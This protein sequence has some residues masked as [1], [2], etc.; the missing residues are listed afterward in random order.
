[1]YLLELAGL[2]SAYDLEFVLF[3]NKKST[4][5]NF[6]LYA[7]LDNDEIGTWACPVENSSFFEKHN[8]N[9]LDIAQYKAIDYMAQK[10]ADN[11]DLYSKQINVMLHT[12]GE[13]EV[14]APFEEPQ[15]YGSAPVGTEDSGLHAGFR[16]SNELNSTGTVLDTSWRG[17]LDK[18]D[19]L[20]NQLDTADFGPKT[21]SQQIKE[22]QYALRAAKSRLR[23]TRTSD[24]EKTTNGV[25]ESGISNSLVPAWGNGKSDICK[26]CRSVNCI[27]LICWYRAPGEDSILD[28]M[29]GA[30][31][32]TRSQFER[33]NEV[34]WS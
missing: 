24:S 31:C 32:G 13:G 12:E 15:E 22:S 34:E 18:A 14:R 10:A 27:D 4:I 2:R 5:S 28:S 26:V 21:I 19:L 9:N 11:T 29:N 25:I 33:Q 30:D 1:M 16:E 23:N 7:N 6:V 20:L 3:A 8:S 17:T